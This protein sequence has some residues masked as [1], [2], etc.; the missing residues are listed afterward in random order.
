[1]N[2]TPKATSIEYF[3]TFNRD[4][5]EQPK[6]FQANLTPAAELLTDFLRTL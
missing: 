3:L 1:M 4:K 2:Y 6:Q 5:A